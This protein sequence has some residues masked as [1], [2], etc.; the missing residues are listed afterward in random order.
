MIRKRLVLY[1][2]IVAIFLI[3]S[4]ICNANENKKV[5]IG[6]EVIKINILIP[7]PIVIQNETNLRLKLGDEIIGYSV[8]KE[9]FKPIHLVN[10]FK[11]EMFEL[12]KNTDVRIKVKRN[13]IEFILKS[14]KKDLINIYMTN[15]IDNIATLTY[16][17]KNSFGA[18][19]HKIKLT[20]YKEIHMEYGEVISSKSF[21]INKSKPKYVGY[22]DNMKEKEYIGIVDTNTKFGISGKI[23]NM[24][25]FKDKKEYEIAEYDEIKMGKAHMSMQDKDGKIKLVEIMITHINKSEKDHKRSIEYKIEDKEFRQERGGVVIGMSGTPIIQNNKII[26]AIA[27]VLSSDPTKGVIVYIGNMIN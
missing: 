1:V 15:L 18:V 4:S 13:K 25:S 23:E 16:V 27:E 8:N 5:K 19:A 26:G 6:G 17:D 2:M 7:K 3:N 14:N 24:D 22:I 21:D 12:P 10:D 11:S 9:E 20:P